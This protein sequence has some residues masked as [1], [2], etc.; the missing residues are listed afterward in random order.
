MIERASVIEQ[1]EEELNLTPLLDC[2]FILVFFFLVATTI[3]DEEA[4]LE[5]QIP[6]ADIEATAP[7]TDTLRIIVAADGS[8]QVGSDGMMIR[9]AGLE[10]QTLDDSL[11]AF[12][13]AHPN[14]PVELVTDAE[15]PMQAFVDLSL[16][17][18]NLGVAMTNLRT[19]PTGGSN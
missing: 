6:R 18:S 2:I 4:Q 3:R 1:E 19:H 12:I 8:A 17:F 16:A 5:V 9:E 10:P 11:R 7:M 14:Q 13:M 15:A